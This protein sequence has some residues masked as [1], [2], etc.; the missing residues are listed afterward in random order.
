MRA[1]LLV[2]W[3]APAI[4]A[5]VLLLI[6]FSLYF[7]GRR[8][9]PEGKVMVLYGVV[10][11]DK[12]GNALTH[13]VVSGKTRYVLPIIQAYQFLDLAPISGETEF[14]DYRA[15]FTVCIDGGDGYDAA[16]ERLLGL[17]PPEIAEKA[18]EIINVFLAAESE[19]NGY[20]E[21]TDAQLTS[22]VR[23]RA[24][25]LKRIGLKLTDISVFRRNV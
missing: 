18:A 12:H 8:K 24:H 13:R 2:S 20:E 15:S 5:A 21:K 23:I 9:I 11:K 17:R 22:S 7:A 16:A 25:E 1:M 19:S 3:I 4:T 14:G 10:G 6:T